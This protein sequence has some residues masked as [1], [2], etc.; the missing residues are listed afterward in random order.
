M[1]KPI[2]LDLQSV[3]DSHQLPFVLIDKDLRIV[4]VNHA[5]EKAYKTRREDMI[6]R[7][8]YEISHHNDRPCA[9]MGEDCPHLCV[10]ESGEPHT[11]LHVHHD[12]LG[13]NHQVRV[14]AYPMAGSDGEQYV[15]EVIEALTSLSAQGEGHKRMV[16]KSPAFLR[17]LERLKLAAVSDVPVLLQGETG[18]GKEV[19][20][21]HIHI[22]SARKERPMLT[23]DCTV[24]TESLFEAEI[25]GHEQGAFT[26]SVGKREGLLEQA[27]S[28]ILFLDE[29]G[30]LQRS[31]QVKLLRV[32]ESGQ[33]RRVGGRKQL[34]LNARII[35]ATNRDLL[36]AVES[37]Q[38]RADLYYRIACLTI[39]LPP[40][41]ERLEDIPL[42]TSELLVR[43]GR[44]TGH[45]YHITPDA[46]ELLKG[47][48]YPG[49][50]RELRNIISVAAANCEHAQIRR[51][52]IDDVIGQMGT[53]RV[54]RNRRKSDDAKT[55]ATATPAAVPAD[56]QSPAS[57]RELE[58]KHI[59][60]L[61]QA[62][63]GNRREVANKLGVSERTVYRKLKRYGLE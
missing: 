38:F 10:Q 40:L 6:G 24:L 4:T 16:G 26:G 30:E 46:V 34:H 29:I 35:C 9:E 59:A 27:N 15:A 51:E 5:Y 55:D 58:A 56:P 62:C 44:I 31:Q 37:G 47:Y 13:K 20:A 28:G 23:L 3:A 53:C 50:I 2:T 14:H 42:I 45:S 25:F 60:E 19:A 43:L 61:L 12:S 49:N 48:H 11:T 32:L 7:H 63:D 33:F 22:L 1:N 52:N 57:L 21:N 39:R 41:R 8:C 17:S 36:P 18:T 54:A